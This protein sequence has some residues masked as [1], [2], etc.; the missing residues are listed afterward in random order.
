M[1]GKVL[2]YDAKTILN[3]GIETGTI[4]TLISLVND[5]LLSVEEAAKRANMTLEEFTLI[6]HKK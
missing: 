1:G 5:G 3:Q 4:N 2:E 6:L